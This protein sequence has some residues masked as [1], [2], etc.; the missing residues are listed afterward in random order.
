MLMPV[1]VE[2][3]QMRIQG[4]DPMEVKLLFYH[5]LVLQ[6]VFVGLIGGQMGTGDMRSGVKFAF[7]LLIFAVLI[8]EIVLLPM[9]P[10]IITPPE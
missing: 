10:P 5:L 3:G 1:E 8:F 7:F 9:G 2:V 4:L 6:A